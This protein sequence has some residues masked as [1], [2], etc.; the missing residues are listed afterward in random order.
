[1]K[2]EVTFGNEMVGVERRKRERFIG[3]QG[4]RRKMI[5]TQD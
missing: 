3:L 5:H 2:E 4:K 1:M